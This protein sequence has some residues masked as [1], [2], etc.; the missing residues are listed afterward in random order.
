[1]AKRKTPFI[2]KPVY[3]GG[4]KAMREFLGKHLRYPEEA[5]Q[6]RT[7][8]SVKVKYS[9]NQRGKVITAEAV[10]GPEDGCRQEAVRLVKLL[11]FTVPKDYKMSV[12]YHQHLMIHFK[13]PVQPKTTVSYTIKREETEKPKD[14]PKPG[15]GYGYTISW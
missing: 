12:R 13:L 5:L 8:G 9:L 2:H 7:E 1:M 15:S 14:T 11:R 6:K 3:P 10:S 4:N